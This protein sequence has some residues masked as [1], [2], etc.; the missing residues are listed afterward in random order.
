MDNKDFQCIYNNRAWPYKSKT[1]HMQATLTILSHCVPLPAPGPPRTNTTLYLLL[2][3]PDMLN[4]FE[5]WNLGNKSV[6]ATISVFG[7][8]HLFNRSALLE[9]KR[10]T[11]SVT[12]SVKH[13]NCKC[14][15]LGSI[16][17]SFTTQ[18]VIRSMI[19]IRVNLPRKYMKWSVKFN[20]YLGNC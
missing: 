12:M 14:C 4:F 3:S 17:S 15:H 9:N 18:D 2:G 5:Y 8:I 20:G 6:L 16:S 19:C 10:K 13:S 1:L 11:F 7:T